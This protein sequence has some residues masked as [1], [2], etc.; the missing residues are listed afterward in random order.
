MLA[1]QSR[2]DEL[3][4]EMIRKINLL[5][6]RQKF[7]FKAKVKATDDEGY[8]QLQF[9]KQE[10]QEQFFKFYDSLL[11]GQKRLPISGPDRSKYYALVS[12]RIVDDY[13]QANPIQKHELPVKPAA[14]AEP[15]KTAPIVAAPAKQVMRDDDT[16]KAERTQYINDR[17][18]LI[19]LIGQYTGLE[20]ELKE[21][22]DT[23]NIKLTENKKADKLQNKANTELQGLMFKT[24][25]A[26]MAHPVPQNSNDLLVSD[27]QPKLFANITLFEE[28]LEALGAAYKSVLDGPEATK[29]KIGPAIEARGKLAAMQHNIRCEIK[30]INTA[31][32]QVK[33]C[34][35]KADEAL[36]MKRLKLEKTKRDIDNEESRWERMQQEVDPNAGVRPDAS[37]NNG[38]NSPAVDSGS[39]KSK[40]KGLHE[41]IHS[42]LLKLTQDYFDY[43]NRF[44]YEEVK[45][46]I[47]EV[48]G[49]LMYLK[50]ERYSK[51][52][53]IINFYHQLNSAKNTIERLKEHRDPSWRRYLKAALI[54]GGILLSG[55]L[56][57]LA[58]LAAYMVNNKR[59]LGSLCFWKS[60]GERFVDKLEEIKP[61]ADE[62]PAP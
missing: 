27:Y 35:K 58:V 22:R 48:R 32:A 46:K 60:E 3:N 53:R 23:F 61:E 52:E 29:L 21:A 16:L 4:E 50:N 19:A 41:E 45:I 30:D 34:V 36:E 40:D 51:K 24:R 9:D 26:G 33:A 7:S 13:F 39:D 1:D 42:K 11:K 5:V 31:I 14:A 55:I 20:K 28:K 12:T 2:E 49:L 10:E 8:F 43:L 15:P 6:D 47:N 18:D 54:A 25:K 59:E 56:P 44:E 17:L 57:G 37:G 62:P 38:K